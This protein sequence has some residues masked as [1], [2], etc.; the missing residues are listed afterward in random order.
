M[1]IFIRVLK[2]VGVLL[3]AVV[4]FAVG[5]I[6]YLTITEFKPA[7]E[8]A[9][10]VSEGGAVEFNGGAVTVLS[11][12]VGYCGLGEESDFFM[13]GGK[14]SLAPSKEV[15]MKNYEGIK[16]FLAETN[17]DFTVLQ[18]VDE[19]SKRSYY[20]RQLE[21]F[22][23]LLGENSAFAYNYKTDYVPFPI[24]TLGKTYSGLLTMSK[25][26][27]ESATRINLPCPF[28]W[29]ISV[30]NLK[31]GLLVTR[32]KVQGT[33]KELVLINLHLEAYDDG[34]GKAQQKK[35]LLDLIN[36]EYEKGNYV[37]AGGDF[38]HVFPDTEALYPNNH[39]DLWEPG[40]FEAEDVKNATLLCD[41]TTPTCRLL[42]QPYAPDDGVNTQY[43]VID[44][45]IV[46]DNIT[47]TVETVDLKFKYSDHNPVKLNAILN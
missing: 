1:K 31:R 29:P 19:H 39:K 8:E 37:I 4:L 21:G 28:S 22:T 15:V 47:A 30:A 20:V 17:A 9:L 45:F 18:E 42:N 26:R 10:T 33:E 23:S 11:W 46:S 36:A 34:E 32:V 13:D 35:K 16:S 25:Y 14:M 27:I 7:E 38:N 40:V 5:L 6:G 44:G 41:K 12:N 43:Y 2:I 3:G 24:P